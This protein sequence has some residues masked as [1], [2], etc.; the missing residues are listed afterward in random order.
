VR[1]LLADDS[2][3]TR[4]KLRRALESTGELRVVG[5]AADGRR[6]IEAVR[7][8]RPEVLL[9]DVVM[10]GMDGL[11]TTA[12]LMATSPLPILIVS[13]LVG[14]KAALNFDALRAGAV[15]IMRKPSAE[16][17]ADAD[18]VAALIRKVRLLAKVP[19][20]TRRRK[21]GPPKAADAGAA[22]PIATATPGVQPPDGVQPAQ[23]I[24]PAQGIQP[25]QRPASAPL[26]PTSWGPASLV[27]IGAST[28]GPPALM[29]LLA[30]LERRAPWPILIVQHIAAG[31]IGSMTR[32]LMDASGLPVV[33]AEH[34]MRVEPGKVFLAPDEHH[35]QIA[36]QHLHLAPRTEPRGH[37]PSVN[38]LFQSVA[39]SKQAR[40]TVGVLLT[41]MGQDGAQGLLAMRGAGAWAIA[42]DRATSVVYGMPKAAAENGAAH[43]VLPLEAIAGRLRTIAGPKTS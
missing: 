37:C 10:P 43:E 32:W 23:G 41:G 35:L 17:L 3:I 34:G 18:R 12:E 22:R 31:F 25:A 42:Q 15:E 14:R 13:D 2:A 27:C 28:G 30:G 6:A 8:F 24:R 21:P 16:E 29:E 19:V 9:L 36:G 26:S 33:L 7:T 1:V 38:A 20:V 5:E 4:L 40:S 11:E 39:A